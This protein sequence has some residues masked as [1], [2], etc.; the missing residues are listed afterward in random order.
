MPSSWRRSSAKL[1]SQPVADTRAER[2]AELTRLAARR[3]KWIEQYDSDHITKGEFE[4]KMHAVTKAALEIEASLPSP[5]P[6]QPDADAAIV[7]LV[8]GLTDFSL[9]EFAEQ[10]NILKR[11]V[12]HFKVMDAAIPEITLSGAF[13]AH[14]KDAQH[15]WSPCTVPSQAAPAGSPWS[16]C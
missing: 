16:R 2:E 9:W 5:S 10:R 15:P 11:V 14:T 3:A 12:K 8:E 13:L 6:P 7:N 4:Q 1:G